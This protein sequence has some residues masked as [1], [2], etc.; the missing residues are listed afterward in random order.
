MNLEDYEYKKSGRGYKVKIAC[1]SCGEEMWQPWNVVKDG[2]GKYCNSTCYN[3]HRHHTEELDQY[4]QRISPS[5]HIEVK[6]NC[7]WC[8][9]E[10]WVKWVRRKKGQGR[11]CNQECSQEYARNEG[12]KTWG[13]EN[14][15]FCW[16]KSSQHWGAFWKDEN[17]I[18]RSTTKAHWLWERDK[19]EI[20]DGYWITYIDENRENC[21]LENLKAVPKGE[22]MS[23]ALMGHK[24]SEEAKKK[25]SESH[26]GK[27]LSEDHKHK[28]SASLVKRWKSGEFESIHC[29]ENSQY[30]RGGIDQ[31]YPPEFN[32]KLKQ[33]IKERDEYKCRICSDGDAD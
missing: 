7:E 31:E 30:W 10:T 29:G 2:R 11:F 6:I 9:A 25:M 1:L 17:G 33:K 12:K 21:V 28:I 5:R 32:D 16:N 27:T 8:G 26:I 3:E 4:E 14:A 15:V 23:K 20:P 22:I 24:H 13:K 19:R 18:Q